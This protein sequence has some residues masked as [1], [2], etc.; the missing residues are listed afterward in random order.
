MKNRKIGNI[1][2]LSPGKYKIRISAGFDD[3]GK[4][5]VISKTVQA[6]SDTEAERI[7]MKIY[8]DRFKI[9]S[10][11]SAPGTLGKLFEIF[12]INHLNNLAPN[13]K[14]YYKTLWK[15]VEK[16]SK[17]QIEKIDIKNINK[18]LEAIPEGK[19]RNGCYK[20]LKTLFN[21][22]QTWGYFSGVNPCELIPA[23]KYK[24]KEKKVLTDNDILI[25]NNH[26]NDEEIKYQCIF[27]LACLLGLRR[28]EILALTWDD[29]NLKSATVSI[30]KA[31]TLSHDNTK[32][33]IIL[34][35]TKTD[36][37]R[38][39]LFLPEILIKKFKALRHEQN[40]RRMKLGD[41][42][43]N[44]N[45]IFTQWNGKVMNVHTPTNWWKGFVKE[46][47]LTPVTFHGLRHS[48]ASIMINAGMDIATVSKTL[49]HSNTST[50]LNIYTHLIEDTKKQAVLTVAEKFA[51]NK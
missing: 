34:K 26:I 27:Y 37:S 11:A 7:L 36:N 51:I 17:L 49:G 46:H 33:R 13:T 43:E 48:A 24:A 40:V 44:H 12:E 3:F 20:L 2:K 8:H 31:V 42:Y 19:L 14:D 21:K 25:I 6:K 22:A 29:L 28:Q 1:Q 47:E 50:T 39:Q 30:N 10:T 9:T 41:L 4:R 45:F 15:H 32:D 16:Y 35:E 18:I 23:P 5:L 38:R